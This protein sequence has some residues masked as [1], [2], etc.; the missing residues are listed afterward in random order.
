MSL[1]TTAGL[2]HSGN[3]ACLSSST[4][5]PWVIDSGAS[6][7]MTG[8]SHIFSQLLG[9][10]PQSSVVLADGRSCS[11][12]GRGSVSPTSSLTLSTVNYIPDFPFSLLSVSQLTKSLNCSVTFFPLFVFFRISARR[13]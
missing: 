8:K 12:L 9:P 1:S 6:A 13:R 3:L 11:I 2:A 4:P 10:P 7:H 5:S